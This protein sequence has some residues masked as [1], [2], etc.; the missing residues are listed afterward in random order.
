MISP[1]YCST[2]SRAT[3]SP[4]GRDAGISP[5]AAVENGPALALRIPGPSSSTVMQ[6]AVGGL[7]HGN[8]HELRAIL[9][10]VIKNVTHH[11]H[12][13]V[14]LADKSDLRRDV[15]RDI[16]PF[17]LI[18]LVES[19][20]QAVKQGAIGVI[21]GS[22]GCRRCACWRDA[23]N[24]QSAARCGLSA[25]RLRL[26]DAIFSPRSERSVLITASGVFRL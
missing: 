18:D 4:T 14:L 17:A 15:E 9:T 21:P 23:G 19:G 13:I 12:K 11:F 16:D 6:M 8:F 10:G 20:S 2:I 25:Q 3:E 7:A 24:N 26:V 22:R 5:L 1:S